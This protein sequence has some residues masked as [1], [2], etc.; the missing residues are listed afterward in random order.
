MRSHPVCTGQG[1]RLG[2]HGPQGRVGTGHQAG[3]WGGEAERGRQGAGRAVSL[4]RGPLRYRE[5]R[6]EN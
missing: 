2:D 5:G 4:L 1:M 6:A 3:G